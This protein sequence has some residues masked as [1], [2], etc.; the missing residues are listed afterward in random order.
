MIFG[1]A[2][3]QQKYFLDSMGTL[4]QERADALEAAL[5][6]RNEVT[7]LQRS[8][9]HDQSTIAELQGLVA[10]IRGS[11]AEVAVYEGLP[12]GND[13]LLLYVNDLVRDHEELE[14]RIDLA[15]MECRSSLKDGWL[16]VSSFSG[17]ISS[18]LKGAVPT[19]DEVPPSS[20]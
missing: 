16:D 1:R 10:A 5:A 4:A 13:T 11:M 9:R 6:L 7:L 19:P 12:I 15:I 8:Q 14:R 3:R 20:G 2:K 17:H 18:I